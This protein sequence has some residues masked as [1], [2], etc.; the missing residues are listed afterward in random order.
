MVIKAN[1]ICNSRGRGLTTATQVIESIFTVTLDWI[2]KEVLQCGTLPPVI[3]C[4]KRRGGS[5][6]RIDSI[7]LQLVLVVKCVG[8]TTILP[9][10]Y[11]SSSQQKRSHR[12]TLWQYWLTIKEPFWTAKQR[13][14]FFNPHPPLLLLH[15]RTTPSTQAKVLNIIQRTYLAIFDT[16]CRRTSSS[17]V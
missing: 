10:Y 8:G 9:F 7:H 4:G 17:S 6:N 2:E 3:W 14:L 16:F 11:S 1:Q 5:I 15:Y 13:S 12:T